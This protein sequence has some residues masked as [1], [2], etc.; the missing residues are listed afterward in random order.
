MPDSQHV[1][2]S[3]SKLRREI[4]EIKEISSSISAVTIAVNAHLYLDNCLSILYF[5]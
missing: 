2:I 3:H 1:P 5:S 4:R